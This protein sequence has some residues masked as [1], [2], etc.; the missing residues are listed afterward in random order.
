MAS[1]VS[2]LVPPILWGY[3]S[4]IGAE[5]TPRSRP[6]NHE[7]ILENILN[8]CTKKNEI[9][10]TRTCWIPNIVKNDQLRS[11]IQNLNFGGYL[12]SFRAESTPGRDLFMPIAVLKHF[13]KNSEKKG[14]MPQN[15][16]LEPHIFKKNI[17]S[18]YK[19]GSNLDR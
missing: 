19:N 18:N 13:L 5:N 12:S 7:N 10:Q 14:K 15:D 9:Y 16:L 1:S 4:T 3:L 2:Q 8:N 6:L 17:R 11:L